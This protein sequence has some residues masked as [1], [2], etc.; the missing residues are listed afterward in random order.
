MAVFTTPKR[1]PPYLPGGLKFGL[2]QSTG[3]HTG[4]SITTLPTQPVQRCAILHTYTATY[5][6]RNQFKPTTAFSKPAT[7]HQTLASVKEARWVD[8]RGGSVPRTADCRRTNRPG[9]DDRGWLR[10]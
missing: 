2:L 4:P 5:P 1:K 6:E 3:R 9:T 10:K 7:S 8:S